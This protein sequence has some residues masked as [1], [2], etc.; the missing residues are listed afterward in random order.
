MNPEDLDKTLE[1]LFDGVI[2]I[3]EGISFEINF[4]QKNHPAIKD[5]IAELKGL[6]PDIYR[7]AL[8][9]VSEIHRSL[10]KTGPWNSRRW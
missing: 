7:R 6:L 4:P 1:V 5:D 2:A 8:K 10:N 9:L 3:N